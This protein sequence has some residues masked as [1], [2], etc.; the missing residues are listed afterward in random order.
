MYY[1]D[2]SSVVPLG[3]STRYRP[4]EEKVE[5]SFLAG[6]KETCKPPWSLEESKA[7][8]TE[9]MLMFIH[10]VTY[11]TTM[12]DEKTIQS[13]FARWG[14]YYRTLRAGLKNAA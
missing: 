9:R 6:Y 10:G 3:E 7:L 2:L 12:W 8:L 1:L 4:V 5:A 13:E 14:Q 11:W